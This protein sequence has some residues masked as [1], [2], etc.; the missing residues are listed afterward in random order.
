[1]YRGPLGET[2]NSVMSLFVVSS[3]E[4]SESSPFEL[5]FEMF[6]Y[7]DQSFHNVKPSMMATFSAGFEP[8]MEDSMKQQRV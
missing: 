6:L 7:L 8:K 5:G 4:Y 1:M 2:G 3:I